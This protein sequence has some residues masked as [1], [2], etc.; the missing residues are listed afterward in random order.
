M[1]SV[2]W[3]IS[4]LVLP[5]VVLQ[6]A[7]AQADPIK[8]AVYADDGTGSSRYSV[9]AAISDTTRF[10]VTE[11]L[12]ADIRAGILQD[13]DVILHPGGSGSGQAESLQESGRDSVRAFISRGGGYL[14]ICA[15][16]YLASSDYTWSLHIL[17]TRVVDKAHW[18]RGYATI[19]VRFNNF[20]RDLFALEQD[21]VAIEY[22]QGAL[23]A[24][25]YVDTLPGY[26]EAGV[27]ESEVA[28]NGAPT[29]VMI[30]TTAF[31]FSVFGEGRVA[32]F[33]PHPEI[34]AGYEY[35]VANAVEWVDR[36]DPFLA[37]IYPRE[38]E[39]WESGSLRTID[40]VSEAENEIVDIEF[41]PDNGATWVPVASNQTE[42]YQWTVADSS[43]ACLM[44]IESLL[45]GSLADT[46]RFAIDPPL[47]SIHSAGGGNWSDPGTWAGG[48]V[49]DSTDNVVIDSGHTV[50]VNA[51]GRCHNLSFADD[52]G[53]LGLQANL[54]LY[55]DFNRYDTSVNP[56]YSGSNLWQ[57]G[58]KMVFTG[59]A[60]VQT[61][62]NLGTTST[63]PYPLRL[64]ELVIDKSAGKFTTNPLVGAEDNLKLGIGTSL[65]IVNGTFEM[66]RSDDIEGRN[67]AGTA[68]T[69]A[70]VVQANGLFTMLGSTSHI[71]RGNFTGEETSKI[72][73][74]TVYGEARL[75]CA[76]TNRANFTDIDV[77][78][79]GELRITYSAAGGNMG[80]ACFNPGTV[81]IK[82]GGTLVNSLNT[83]IWY[84]NATTPN[85]IALLAGGI[86]DAN[87]SA[88]VYPSLSVNEGTFRYSRSSGNQTVLDMD[89]HNLELSYSSGTQKLWTL[90]AD[91]VV[92]GELEVNNSA[93]LVV[94]SDAARTLTVGTS[95]RLTSGAIDN[96]DAD[97]ALTVA[98]GATV[99]RATG[100][101]STAPAF[102][103][104]ADVRYTSTVASVT[105]GPELPLGSGVLRDLTVLGTLGVTLGAGV[106]VNGTCSLT[107]S[108]LVT[109]AYTVTL[110]PSATLV[111]SA[112]ATIVGRATT[113]RTVGQSVPEAFG[114]LGLEMTAAGAAP[115]TTTVLRVTGTA[116]PL[117]GS[118]GMERYFDVVPSV[119]TG[120]GATAVFH[121]DESEL[122]GID[123]VAL[124]MYAITRGG[125]AQ[126]N[127]GGTVDVSG[128][129]VTVSGID[130]LETLTL[131]PATVT[132]AGPE[133]TPRVTRLIAAYPN[134]FSPATTIAFELSQP[135]RVTIMVFDVAGRKVRTLQDGMM[136][137]AQHV[138]RWSGLDDAGQRVAPGVYFCRL[139][140]GKVVQTTRLSLM[141]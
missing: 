106:T 6:V 107:G 8:V 134:P 29:G 13:F 117:A 133:V 56:F 110:G 1:R 44:R 43:D 92:A 61:I 84:V 38:H 129:T 15:G 132:D 7:A 80:A 101:L 63:S 11:V 24:P 9:I 127:L 68:T 137:A 21:T 31:A 108:D 122:N 109:G 49:P 20:G 12:G 4:L 99:T 40:W 140:A 23:M 60:E 86:V 2:L 48:S 135:E 139:V 36:D 45:A 59:D 51:A 79:G 93:N 96:S 112:G 16:S 65:E 5:L 70:I 14:G 81:T 57:A 35:M 78:D 123:E 47:P 66:S 128:N 25:A 85:Q 33:S 75:A 71:R 116:K 138:V 55:G 19:D 141:R 34:T 42:P 94:T 119:N 72:G 100:T 90:G 3:C 115:G 37:L 41:S 121:Y 53:R 30:G 27:F 17:N 83:N 26:I 10:D 64:Q 39:H 103:G 131:G 130:A 111:E 89:Y 74:M 91:R 69:P 114:G 98:D 22:R 126:E 54:Y 102:A 82:D 32:V 76:T 104:V 125:I 28:E 105:T 46:I 97:A 50:I 88:P 77:E 67:P 58:A 118:E 73:K 95:L 120:L 136:G 62:N 52:T 124:A 87:S 113:T 18:D